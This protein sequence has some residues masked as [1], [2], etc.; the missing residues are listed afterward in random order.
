MNVMV[1]GDVR[2]AARA[3]LD[4]EP[5]PASGRPAG[6]GAA[7][8]T[9]ARSREIAAA[10]RAFERLLGERVGDRVVLVG[11]TSNL[12]LAA[13]LVASK[14]RI[15]VAAVESDAPDPGDGS[16]A[17]NRRLIEQLADA[18]VADDAEA[19]S[20]WLAAPQQPSGRPVEH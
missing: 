11:S 10:L 14:V 15:P 20:A 4:A 13:V 9:P 18:A 16:S 12:A 1:V 7:R 8:R 5:R 17:S 19:I 6:R 3:A 2:L